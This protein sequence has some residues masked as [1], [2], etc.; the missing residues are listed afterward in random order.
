VD[1]EPLEER[2]RR[3]LA[4]LRERL[5][6]EWQATGQREAEEMAKTVADLELEDDELHEAIR[7]L[8]SRYRGPKPPP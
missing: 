3:A 8:M 1:M 7:R 5:R 4:G 6:G 2:R